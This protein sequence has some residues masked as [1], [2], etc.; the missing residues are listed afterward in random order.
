MPSRRQ[1][2]TVLIMVLLFLTVLMMMAT[3]AV[4]SGVSEE[5][6]ARANRDY[7]I[8]FQA[9]EAGLRDAHADLLGMGSRNPVILG[10]PTFAA[11]APGTCNSNGLCVPG[12]VTATPVWE[13]T[14]YWTSNTSTYGQ[15]TYAQALPAS[16]PGSV[17][18]PPRYMIEFLGTV[19]SQALY[20]ITARGW[21]PIAGNQPVTLQEEV[22]R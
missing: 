3:A 9:A 1:Q 10:A 12:P 8:G 11:I 13:N 6:L 21:G 17:S 5:R 2:G 22:L 19:G 7:N 20:R 16:G 14:T 15:Y 4:T 18:Q